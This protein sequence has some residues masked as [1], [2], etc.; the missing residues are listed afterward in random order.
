[1]TFD[2]DGY[3]STGMVL[4]DLG[5]KELI[6]QIVVPLFNPTG[7][8][9]GVGDDCALVDL[10]PGESLLISTDRVPSDLTAFRLGLLDYRGLGGYL[11]RLNLSDIAASG[12]TPRGLLLNLGLPSTLPVRHFVALLLGAHEI[13]R[14]HEI[15]IIGGDLSDA[16]EVSISATAVGSVKRSRALSR[17]TARVG[18]LVFIS[19]PLGLTPAAFE[20][21]RS[22]DRLLTSLSEAEVLALNQQFSD[23]APMFS[24]AAALS[25]S[26]ICTSCM[27]NTDGIGQSLS[28]IAERSNVAI[29]V[30]RQ[31][32][33]FPEVVRKI[34]DGAERDLVRLAFAGGADFSL[35][36]TVSVGSEKSCPPEISI[37][38]RVVPGQGVHLV[39]EKGLEPLAIE[40]W[41]YY[42]R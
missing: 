20:Y 41:N 2:I 39:Q 31:K 21:Y 38:G 37:V 33:V 34:A 22:K 10:P 6:R 8:Q 1:M 35:V 11:A 3:L 18:D 5:E 30:D 36:G 19:R 13:A 29:V 42:R 40:G 32:L 25:S 24:L 9:W 17:Q 14:A 27:D 7:D 28:E 4:A 23:S 15:E 26:G 12:G 16:P